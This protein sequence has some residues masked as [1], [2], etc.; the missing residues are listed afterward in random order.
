MALDVKNP[1]LFKNYAF[2][3]NFYTLISSPWNCSPES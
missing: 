2:E 3:K 1:E